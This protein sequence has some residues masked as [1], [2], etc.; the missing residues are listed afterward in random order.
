MSLFHLFRVPPLSACKQTG[1]VLFPALPK[2][3]VWP[4][5]WLKPEVST[6]I[7]LP[8]RHITMT[9]DIEITLSP[10]KKAWVTPHSGTFV[11]HGGEQGSFRRAGQGW[12]FS[13]LK[14]K[15]QA[16]QRRSG[17]FGVKKR[18]WSK[19]YDAAPTIEFTSRKEKG[20]RFIYAQNSQQACQE[21]RLAWEPLK[22]KQLYVSLPCS[23]YFA[24]LC[25]ILQC[26]LYH[27]KMSI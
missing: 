21:L 4:G 8:P 16:G 2:W 27:S 1:T 15:D 3:T 19:S 20:D 12:V 14:R 24:A 23:E 25:D 13:H 18:F 17:G 10:G 7:F 22:T 9:T 26:N 11:V 6:P 5:S